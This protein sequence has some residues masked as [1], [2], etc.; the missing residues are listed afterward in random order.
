MSAIGE[1]ANAVNHLNV[2]PPPAIDRLIVV[3]DEREM[4]IAIIKGLKNLILSE[5]NILKLINQNGLVLIGDYFF[6]FFPIFG[7]DALKQIREAGEICKSGVVDFIIQIS[8]G[9]TINPRDVNGHAV[10][11]FA[12]VWDDIGG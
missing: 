2:A 6:Q 12:K 4:D 8:G 3:S 9:Q 1:F 11:E 7:K 5:W 10:K